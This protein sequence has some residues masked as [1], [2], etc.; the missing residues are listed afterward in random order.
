MDFF[1]SAYQG[2]PPW[3]IGRP[4]KE[5][6]DLVLRGEMKGS[7]LDIGCG[8]G[9]HALFFAGEGFDV[10]GIDTSPLAIG[11]AKEKAAERGLQVRFLVMNA[12]EIAKIGRKFDTATD[13]GF[14]HTLSDKDRVIFVNNLATVLLPGGTYYMLCFS[15]LEPPG[16][17]PRRI[18]KG[19][20]ENSFGEGWVINYIRSAIFESIRRDKG[21]RA[22]LTS[23]TKK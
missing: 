10:W 6:V 22:W 5:F 9:E 12:L 8:T 15:D 21:S 20:I 7:V 11:M 23:I 19:E 4:Q 13:S 16:Y 18:A 3:D 17:G 1:D 14:F 2:R